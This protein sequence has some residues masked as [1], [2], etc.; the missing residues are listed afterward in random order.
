MLSYS[1]MF[2]LLS[3]EI[4]VLN[5][6]THVS[7]MSKKGRFAIY[8]GVQVLPILF[9]IYVFLISYFELQF[10]LNSLNE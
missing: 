2:T 6:F 10:I 5:V 1:G 8:I 3:N 9:R 7:N 4:N